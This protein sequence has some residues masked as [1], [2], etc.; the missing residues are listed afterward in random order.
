MTGLAQA[1]PVDGAATIGRSDA[2]SNANTRRTDTSAH[3][4]EHSDRKQSNLTE[5]DPIL[6]RSDEFKSLPR[7]VKR[8]CQGTAAGSSATHDYV[9]GMRGVQRA[10]MPN[11]NPRLTGYLTAQDPS[12]EVAMTAHSLLPYAHFNKEASMRLLIFFNFMFAIFARPALAQ[13]S[14]T[15]Q[16]TRA[17]GRGLSSISADYAFQSAPAG[18]RNLKSQPSGACKTLWR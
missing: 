6:P 18:V 5:H 3:P 1:R 16:E 15:P 14:L 2:R 17:R 7:G 11:H 9:T 12:H 10:V 4:R 8:A 13:T